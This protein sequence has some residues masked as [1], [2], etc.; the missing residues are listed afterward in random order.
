MAATNSKFAENVSDPFARLILTTLSSMCWRITA[1]TR[2]PN[3]GRLNL[4]SK[5]VN[6]KR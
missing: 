6:G 5:E 4:G 2:I 3:S 1:R